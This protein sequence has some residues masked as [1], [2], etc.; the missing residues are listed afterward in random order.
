MPIGQTLSA[1]LQCPM[2]LSLTHHRCSA[3]L[4]EKKGFL[5]KKKKFSI[6]LRKS[7]WNCGVPVNRTSSMMR[8]TERPSCF[9]CYRLTKKLEATE[10]R[11]LALKKKYYNAR[12]K[13]KNTKQELKRSLKTI[14]VHILFCQ[15]LK[16][17]IPYSITCYYRSQRK[18]SSFA[19]KEL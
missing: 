4:P 7:C 1:H 17:P 13:L 6:S 5:P 3:L 15:K 2:M 12:R 9:N 11:N 14:E 10:E 19:K 8:K 16:A 18:R